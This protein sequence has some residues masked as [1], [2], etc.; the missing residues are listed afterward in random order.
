M[1]VLVCDLDLLEDVIYCCKMQPN[2]WY[3]AVLKITVTM[4]TDHYYVK[5]DDVCKGQTK[6]KG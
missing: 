5:L 6:Y 2:I 4:V 1:F 3:R